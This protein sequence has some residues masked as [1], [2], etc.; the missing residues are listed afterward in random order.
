MN[1]FL[2]T[3]SYILAGIFLN[4]CSDTIYNYVNDPVVFA[5]VT[6]R[7]DFNV[8][9]GLNMAEMTS[10]LHI[11]GNVAISDELYLAGAWSNYN[12]SSGTSA[13]SGFFSQPYSREIQSSGNSFLCGLG[14]Y[15]SLGSSDFNFEGTV[16]AKYG[17][18]KNHIVSSYNPPENIDYMHMKYYVQ[19]GITYNG[20]YF[21]AGLACRLGVVDYLS[22][23]TGLQNKSPEIAAKGVLP[24]ADPAVF[25][26]AGSKYIKLGVQFSCT[27]GDATKSSILP[28]KYPLDVS[29]DPVS[30]SVFLR[31]TIPSGYA[32]IY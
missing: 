9:G 2:K 28:Y 14:Y 32:S 20:E 10:G 4:S 15:S 13:G 11:N 12:K 22:H 1:V 16:G 5:N 24:F 27:F 3:I 19:P 7:S 29:H 18:N 30:F 8:S 23:P 26:C 21:Q 17:T 6:S 31:V 25:V